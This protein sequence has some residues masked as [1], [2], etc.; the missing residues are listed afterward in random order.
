MPNM[1]ESKAVDE[2]IVELGKGNVSPKHNV[3]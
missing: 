1:M 2:K 3:Q